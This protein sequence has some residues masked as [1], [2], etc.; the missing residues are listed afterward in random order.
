MLGHNWFERVSAVTKS[1]LET[2]GANL[3]AKKIAN[4]THREPAG[5]GGAGW[6]RRQRREVR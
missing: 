3:A 5:R 6:S 1:D 2:V 4:I